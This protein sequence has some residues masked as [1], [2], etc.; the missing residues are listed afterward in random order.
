MGRS[1]DSIQSTKT[2]ISFFLFLPLF[3]FS[4]L[5][6]LCFFEGGRSLGFLS[7][8]FAIILRVGV[9]MEMAHARLGW[10]EFEGEFTPFSTGSRRARG[11]N[12]VSVQV[13]R[14]LDGV[15]VRVVDN[16]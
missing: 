16:S 13:Q 5:L 14:S 4:C 2:E 10:Q 6:V 9:K 8:P 3:F 1:R 12:S 15:E 7:I 11:L